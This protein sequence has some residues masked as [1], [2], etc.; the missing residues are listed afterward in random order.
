M[1]L[2]DR[3]GNLLSNNDG[4][5]GL[6]WIS[7]TEPDELELLFQKSHKKSQVIYKHS[8]RCGVSAMALSNL[9]RLNPEK[10]E[11]ADFYFLNV[12][13]QRRLSQ[14]VAE[15]LQVRHESPQLII[16]RGGEVIWNGSHYQVSAGA[17]SEILLS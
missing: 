1:S 10:A 17:L 3:I 13:N 9:H 8:T 5:I 2:L 14:H 15:K 11:K 12:I 6:D 16:I 7:L 4:D